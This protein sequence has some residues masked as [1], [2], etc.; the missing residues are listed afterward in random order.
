[1]P[2]PHQGTTQVVSPFGTAKSPFLYLAATSGIEVTINCTLG[3]YLVGFACSS[4]T[5]VLVH[6]AREEA[7]SLSLFVGSIRRFNTPPNLPSGSGGNVPYVPCS[8]LFLVQNLCTHETQSELLN[9]PN[10]C[11]PLLPFKLFSFTA[12]QFCRCSPFGKQGLIQAA[13]FVHQCMLQHKPAW[14]RARHRTLDDPA[15]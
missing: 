6:G 10:M 7:L 14:T 2:S 1:V 13:L 5:W 3:F 9:L 4:E 11:N 8:N 15:I 12:E